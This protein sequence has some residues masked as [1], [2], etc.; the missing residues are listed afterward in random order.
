MCGHTRMFRIIP[1]SYSTLYDILASIFI[2]S[3]FSKNG[4]FWYKMSFVY[5]MNIHTGEITCL[6]D[7]Y[8]HIVTQYGV[9]KHV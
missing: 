3:T 6:L 5:T 2:L 4:L 8:A 7:K 1:M 9:Q